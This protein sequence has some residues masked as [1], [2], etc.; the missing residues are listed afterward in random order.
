MSSPLS[1]PTTLR[2]TS[3]LAVSWL[4]GLAAFAFL[5]GGL[6]TE[7]LAKGEPATLTPGHYK[8]W[9]GDLDEL[10]VLQPFKLADYHRVVVVPLT[11]QSVEMP[12]DE[13]IAPTRAVLAGATGPFT[14]GLASHLPRGSQLPVEIGNPGKGGAGAL[15]VRARLT[16][17]NPGSRAARYW[18]GFGAGAAEAT[19]SG[20]VIDGRT[21][22]P[23]LRFVQKRRSG[24]GGGGGD[25]LELMNRC[26]GEIGQDVAS[27]LAAAR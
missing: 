9:H 19:I 20:E 6:V 26:L 25:Y 23:L 10:D 1:F 11:S 22:K 18:G 24:L 12:T 21:G 15:I 5:F 2:R 13:T 3:P 8:D 16:Q 27:A 4:P 14:Q 17:L 7:T